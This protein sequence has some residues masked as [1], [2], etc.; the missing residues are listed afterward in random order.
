MCVSQV[1]RRLALSMRE[2]QH[3]MQADE[4]AVSSS[5]GS[6]VE[7][8]SGPRLASVLLHD[9]VAP[10]AAGSTSEEFTEFGATI[11]FAAG[12]AA[13]LHLSGAAECAAC[14]GVSPLEAMA[15]DGSW[16]RLDIEV[17]DEGG[18]GSYISV[19][20]PSEIV[21]LRLHW[22]GYPQCALYNGV[23]GPDSHTALAAAPFQWCVHGTV[24]GAGAW[25]ASCSP[26]SASS[27][28][29]TGVII[30]VAIG[31]GAAAVGVSVLAWKTVCQ[32]PKVSIHP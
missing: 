7:V 31:G 16:A 26:T 17:H 30:G 29:N 13:S 11:R 15:A 21:G 5:P 27:S 25:T 22:E 8:Y 4:Q 9:P 12:T 18:E 28:D 24:G 3:R 10:G 14:C 2:V 23:G 1:G 19:R 20:S 6:H 32:S